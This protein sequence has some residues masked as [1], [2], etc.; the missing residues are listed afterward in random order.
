MTRPASPPEPRL[1]QDQV[2]RAAALFYAAMTVVAM[3]VGLATDNPL[4]WR[5]R[6]ERLG[7]VLEE[8]GLGLALGAGV[9]LA[10]SLWTRWTSWGRSFERLVRDL[11]GPLRWSDCFVLALLSSLG[12][13]L[14]FRGGLQPILGLY[15]TSVLFALAH[16]PR[17]RSLIPWTAMAGALGLVFGLMAE[18]SGQLTGPIAA[19]FLVNFV[20]LRRLT[21][22]SDAPPPAEA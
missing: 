19:H 8:L 16:W 20:N 22:A 17:D 4:L 12:E 9:L 18:R 5:R 10:S 21:R 14:L 11:F 15:P 13:E 3:L 6:P 1:T 2:L 7:V